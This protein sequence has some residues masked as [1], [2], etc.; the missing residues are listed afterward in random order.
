M[1]GWLEGD[2]LGAEL[3]TADAFEDGMKLLL[4]E[5][6]RSTEGSSLKVRDGPGDGAWLGFNDGPLLDVGLS[7]GKPDGNVLGSSEVDVVGVCTGRNDGPFD[8]LGIVERMTD[9][10]TLNVGLFEGSNDG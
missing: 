6:V 9:G 3:G 7:D 1:L 4:G 5:L 2:L 8:K 10:L